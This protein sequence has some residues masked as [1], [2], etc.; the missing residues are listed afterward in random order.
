MSR[1]AGGSVIESF[2]HTHKAPPRGVQFLGEGS[3]V[4]APLSEKRERVTLKR[5]P[6]WVAVHCMGVSVGRGGHVCLCS[7]ARLKNWLIE[8]GGKA[9][10]HQNYQRSVHWEL[11]KITTEFS[12]PVSCSTGMRNEEWS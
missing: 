4:H 1:G 9:L 7:T 12:N 6:I 2:G 8:A 10:S 3:P 5:V 11:R